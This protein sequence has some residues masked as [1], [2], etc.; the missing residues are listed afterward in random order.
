M[1]KSTFLSLLTSMLL[2]AA[3]RLATAKPILVAGTAVPATPENTVPPPQIETEPAAVPEYPVTAIPLNGPV[4]QRNAEVSGMAWY[5]DWL[6][7]MPQYPDFANSGGDG[8]LYAL[9]KADILAFLDGE[10]EALLALE[11]PFTAPGL[12]QKVSGYEGFE[13]IA[14]RGDQV[15]MTIE[16][17]TV[18][19]MRGYLAAGSIQP[20]LSTV[21]LDTAVLTEIL[22]QNNIGNKSDEALFIAGDRVVTLY[23]TNGTAVNPAPVAH[24]FDTALTAVDAIPFP[25]IEYRVTDVTELDGNGRFWA[26]NYFFPGDRE[27]TVNAD[28][29]TAQSG[30]GVTHQQYDYVE[31]LIQFQ[32]TDAGISFSGAPPIQ[33]ELIAQDARNWEGIVRLDERGFLLATDKFPTTILGFVP[34]SQ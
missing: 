13:A 31:R 6:I 9:R 28:P 30:Q 29:L 34:A 3:C 4:S 18:K 25:N 12:R 17:R 11:V 14:F 7:L 19:G 21:T 27:L 15:F 20:D 16:A 23:E 32:Y 33:L 24:R 26:I 2:L 8:F 22:P 5:G 1:K 10:L